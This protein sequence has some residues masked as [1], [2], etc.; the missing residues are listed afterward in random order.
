MRRM[1]SWI[2]AGVVWREREMRM[3]ARAR[4]GG[5]PMASQDVGGLGGTGLAGAAAGDGEAV[6]VEG[7]DEGLGFDAVEVEVGGIGRA[8]GSGCVDSGVGDLGEE[9]LLEVVAEG[10]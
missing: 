8:G 10:G 3:E 2:S 9:G 5:R 4:A 7:D 6:E 1:A